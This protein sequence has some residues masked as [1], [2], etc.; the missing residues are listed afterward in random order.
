MNQEKTT[1]ILITYS[2]NHQSSHMEIEEDF[3]SIMKKIIN[4]SKKN[5]FLR[6]NDFALDPKYIITVQQIEEK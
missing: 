5:I 6:F 3:D 4:A 2:H 1:S